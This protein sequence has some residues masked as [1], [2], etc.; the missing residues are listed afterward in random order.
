MLLPVVGR[1]FLSLS[2]CSCTLAVLLAVA[3]RTCAELPVLSHLVADMKQGP[4]QHS[5]LPLKQHQR[6]SVCCAQGDQS[7]D[8]SQGW[9]QGGGDAKPAGPD[10]K[11]MDKHMDKGQGWGQGGGDG[12]PAGPDDKHMDKHMDKGQ[13][14]AQ[15]GG[16]AKPAGPGDKH[17]DM[18]QGWAQGGG[19]KHMDMD[20]HMDK[21]QGWG[22]GGG[23]KHM[24][25]DKHMDKGQGWAQG[26]G[27]AQGWS[28]GGGDA[29][30]AGP[31]M[32]GDAKPA[33]NHAGAGGG[34]SSGGGDAKQAG[35]DMHGDAKKVRSQSGCRYWLCVLASHDMQRRVTCLQD[36]HSFHCYQLQ[37]R[38]HSDDYW[39]ACRTVD[40]ECGNNLKHGLKRA[41]TERM[42]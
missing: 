16:D 40:T 5:H 23:D 27:W 22:Q 38:L 30:P 20:K 34:W 15:G 24:D 14:W 6:R 28:K 39:F 3:G 8:K 1:F 26:G 18:S 29:K 13:G 35:P 4:A 33:D 2:A 19:D 21:G 41:D 32:H 9:A 36:Y 11:H 10:D 31:D 25:M 7:G 12:K 37:T 42:D 17:M